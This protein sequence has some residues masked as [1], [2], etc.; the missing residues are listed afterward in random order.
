MASEGYYA[1]KTYRCGRIGEKVKF[2][3]PSLRVRTGEKSSPEK[4]QGNLNNAVRRAARI[5]NENFRPGDGWLTFTY[6][7]KQYERVLKRAAKMDPT[8]AEQDRLYEAAEHEMRLCFDRA[9]PVLKKMGIELKYFAVTSDMDADTG[10]LVRVHHHVV[11]PA[12]CVQVVKEKWGGDE[13]TDPKRPEWKDRLWEQEDYTPLAEYM[14]KQ[15]RHMPDA[16]KWMSSRNL[17]RSDP[18][19]RK[20]LSGAPLRPPKGCKL[21]YADPYT[22]VRDC[23]YIR[24]LLPEEE[25]TGVWAK[26]KELSDPRRRARGARDL[27]GKSKDPTG[28]VG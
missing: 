10:E 3:V 14:V 16:K 24:Y 15:V 21:L 18:K 13:Y 20:V 17:I 23:Q 6:D 5:L 11:V 12:D 9:R 22:G 28:G 7:A 25:W 8:K 27:N 1:T 26:D 19:P 2:F 4:I